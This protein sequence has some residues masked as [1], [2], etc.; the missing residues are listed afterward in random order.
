[1]YDKKTLRVIYVVKEPE[2][3]TT[4]Q[5]ALKKQSQGTTIQKNT[6]NQLSR[7]NNKWIL[8]RTTTDN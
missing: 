1:M 7:E 5:E 3:E 2:D 4:K 6:G 8:R